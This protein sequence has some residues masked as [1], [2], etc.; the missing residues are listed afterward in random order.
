MIMQ[1]E[2]STTACFPHGGPREGY[3]GTG[4]DTGPGSIEKGGDFLPSALQ[5]CH[6]PYTNKGKGY[7]ESEERT[8]GV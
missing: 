8:V 2:A 4:V 1:R 7:M 5:P 3:L 6:A